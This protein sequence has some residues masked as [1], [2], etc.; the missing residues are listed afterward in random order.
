MFGGWDDAK[1]KTLLLWL[2]GF[3]LKVNPMVHFPTQF[4]EDLKKLA[5]SRHCKVPC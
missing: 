4:I 5:A 1:Q 3:D 2:R